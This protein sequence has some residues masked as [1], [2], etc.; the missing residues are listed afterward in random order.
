MTWRPG[1]PP[2]Q[3]TEPAESAQ[4]AQPAAGQVPGPGPAGFAGKVTLTIPLATLTDLA[5]RP[6][7]IAGIGPVD[8]WLARDLASAAAAHPKTT[9]CMTVTDEQGHAVG[10]GCARPQLRDHRDRDGPGFAFT[11]ADAH[12]P[13]GGYGTWRL[14]TG[15]G[16]PGLIVTL[17]PISTESCDHRFA[18]RGHDPGVRLRHLSQVRHATCTGPGCRRPAAACD[19]EHP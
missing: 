19:F 10:H 12:G 5:D 11:A 18:S 13:P 14:S 4:P 9:W 2:T 8:P 1:A 7:E 3:P 6:G 15:A 16:G 17:D